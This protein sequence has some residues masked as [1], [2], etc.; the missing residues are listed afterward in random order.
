MFIMPPGDEMNIDWHDKQ[1]ARHVVQLLI[2]RSC[3]SILDNCSRIG[4]WT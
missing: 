2:L 4:W 3:W 1:D